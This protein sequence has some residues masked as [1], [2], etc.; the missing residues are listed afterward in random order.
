M[1]QRLPWMR[2]ARRRGNDTLPRVKGICTFRSQRFILF[3]RRAGWLRFFGRQ[4]RRDQRRQ[5]PR[6][7][8]PRHFNPR[9]L[10]RGPRSR[11]K[12]RPKGNIDVEKYEVPKHGCQQGFGREICSHPCVA[13]ERSLRPAPRRSWPIEQRPKTTPEHVGR[14]FPRHAELR[15]APQHMH[16]L[17]RSDFARSRAALFCT[18]GTSIILV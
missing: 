5:I 14:R 13:E 12:P 8:V 7:C 18:H 6:R 17:G 16:A 3:T 1:N 9:K 11:R 10:L 4:S 2:W 15:L